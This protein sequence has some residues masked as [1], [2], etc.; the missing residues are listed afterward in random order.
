[1]AGE[2]AL[3]H[4]DNL[5]ACKLP[6]EVIPIDIVVQKAQDMLTKRADSYYRS[7]VTL[8]VICLA[9]TTFVAFYL[10]FSDVLILSLHYRLNGNSIPL[11]DHDINTLFEFVVAVI[12][13]VAASGAMLGVCYMLGATA[14]SCFRESTILLHRR[15]LLRYVRLVSHEK[16]GKVPSKDL[17][18]VFGVDDV[19]NTGF[20]R[21]KPETLKDNL[22][23]KLL[24][25]LGAALYG[26]LSGERPDRTSAT[27]SKQ[28]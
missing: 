7:G 17:R 22:V 1:M 9:V 14:N 26:K 28:R 16:K 20:D 23:G 6:P 25:A 11:P 12:R 2:L 18:A 24:D 8:F 27:K 15:H 4:K 21:I 5:D 19:M 3:Q 10:T 13:R